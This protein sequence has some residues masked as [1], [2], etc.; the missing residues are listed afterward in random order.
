VGPAPAAVRDRPSHIEP[1]AGPWRFQL[2]S[3]LGSEVIE[4][5]ILAATA[6]TLKAAQEW[7]H[8]VDLESP[9]DELLSFECPAPYRLGDEV[10]H[11]HFERILRARAYAVSG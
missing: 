3:E 1:P 7:C 5:E 10:G 2:D 6:F 4:V 11:G 8:G 9:D